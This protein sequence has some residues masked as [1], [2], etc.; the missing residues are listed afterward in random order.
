MKRASFCLASALALA[1]LAATT[2]L[3]HGQTVPRAADPELEHLDQRM[4][5]FLE[6]LS[7]DDVSKAYRD[8]LQGG[9]LAKEAEGISSLEQKTRAIQERHG[10]FRFAEQI[11]ARR[12]GKDVVTLKYLYHCDTSPVAWHVTFYRVYK[13]NETP[14]DTEGWH[15]ISLRFD[16]NLEALS[17]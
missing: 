10:A 11:A 5:T 12:T 6:R 3:T 15:L 14:R 8:L 2:L 7:F 9:P 1:T 13:R 16:T 17:P 4:R